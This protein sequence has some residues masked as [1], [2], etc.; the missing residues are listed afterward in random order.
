MT[1]NNNCIIYESG[2]SWQ[3]GIAEAEKEE[4][5]RREAYLKEEAIRK[6][7]RQEETKKVANMLMKFVI[8][9]DQDRLQTDILPEYF[10]FDIS[11][12]ET[13]N[14]FYCK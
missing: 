2:V 10:G 13:V 9:T 11:F 12:V 7:R 14:Y 5:L 1:R 4:L 3:S 6:F 8:H